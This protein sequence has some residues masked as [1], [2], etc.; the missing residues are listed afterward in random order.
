[1]HTQFYSIFYDV[2][3]YYFRDSN[4]YHFCKKSVSGATIS[5]FQ[6]KYSLTLN[7]YSVLGLQLQKGVLL[8]EYLSIT[9]LVLRNIE[10]LKHL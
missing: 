8:F 7:S 10:E 5:C 3:F 4:I 6:P 2:V 1:M 9:K